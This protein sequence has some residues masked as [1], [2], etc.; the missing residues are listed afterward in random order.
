[1]GL[2][3]RTQ[4]IWR[5]PLVVRRGNYHSEH[6]PCWYAVRKGGTAHWSG[7]TKQSTVWEISNRR[8]AGKGPGED[9]STDHGTQKPVA[10][11]LRPILNHTEEGMSVYDPFM[12]SGTTMIAAEQSGRIAYGLDIDPAYVDVAIERWERLTGEEARLADDGRTF[13]E[14]KAARAKE[15]A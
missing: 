6:E 1:M 2:E 10:C 9:T 7:G 4:I 14:V 8:P 5:K 12:G 3:L 15:A 11:M 13:G